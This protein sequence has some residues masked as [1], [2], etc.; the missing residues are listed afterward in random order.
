MHFWFSSGLL[1]WH[2]ECCDI[3]GQGAEFAVDV[4]HHLIRASCSLHITALKNA[5]EGE[6]ELILDT[7]GLYI[8]NVKLVENMDGT[9]APPATLALCTA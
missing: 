8:H 1:D 2:H 7:R 6:A 9:C 4:C 5:Q 3:C